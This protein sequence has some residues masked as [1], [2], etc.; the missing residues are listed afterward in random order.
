MHWDIQSVD[1]TGGD[2]LDFLALILVLLSTWVFF[3]LIYHYTRVWNL[4]GSFNRLYKELCAI[5][6]REEFL[7]LA[8]RN[9]CPKRL[10]YYSIDFIVVS[11]AE[12]FQIKNQKNNAYLY[13]L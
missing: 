1:Y 6:R 13:R 8:E 2:I 11:L 5:H 9:S 12:I 7:G 4:K 10:K 3:L